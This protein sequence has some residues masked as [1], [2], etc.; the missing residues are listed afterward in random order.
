MMKT[1]Y[2][3]N[4]YK[5]AIIFVTAIILL[6]VT[7]LIRSSSAYAA[8]NGGNLIDN[9]LFRNTNSMSA[10]QIQS[11][12]SSKGS[13]LASRSFVLN[14]YAADSKEREWYTAVGAPCDQNIPASQIIYY[15]SKIYGVNP[16]VVLATLQKEQ[17][18]ITS[19][20][21]TSWQISQAMGYACP[22]SGSCSSESNFFYQIDSGVWVMRYH[23]ERARGNMDWWNPSTT[24]TCG[25][26]KK[27][28][29]PNLYPNQNVRF[30]DEN[31]VL[32]RTHYI[33]N[34]AT[35]S[36]Y[37]YTPHAYNNPEGLYG[38]DPYGS[39]GMYYSGS[40]NFVYWFEIWF[41]PTQSDDTF[42][43]HPNGTLIALN[44]KVYKIENGE[45][46]HITHP[47]VLFS[48]RY[49][50][51]DVRKAKTGDYELPIGAPINTLAAG[52]IY[53]TKD[54]PVYVVEYED[55]TLKR[56][57]ISYASFI[58]L[59]YDWSKV[60]VTVTSVAPRSTHSSLLTN[61]LHPSGSIVV[62][63]Q[64]G[65][66][67]LIEE[68]KKRH[69]VNPIA[70]ESHN[71]NWSDVQ[72]ITSLDRALPNG[73]PLEIRSGTMLL[74]GGIYVV[75]EDANGAFKRPLGPW[76][77]YADRLEYTS[78]DWIVTPSSLLPKRTGSTYTC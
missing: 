56:R 16:Q 78:S 9:V 25:T 39:T 48:Y 50:W 7:L 33:Q 32:Y 2:I 38:R 21:P 44:N 59:E 47:D 55:G 24:W 18:L 13:G 72:E 77:C 64:A 27:Y 10:A 65:K 12:L 14:C 30:Y 29:K 22:T 37:C 49:T 74:S 17:S 71:Y 1:Y 51:N 57:H 35:S 6:V 4:N 36:L 34:A 31:D 68:G 40:Y 70:F 66:V 41:G 76:E 19:P 52:T 63:K 62:D 61:N 20:N 8:Y 73:K 11:F 42:S 3:L 23:Y 26:E 67:Y 60:L 75:D 28:Y 53:R 5:K 45:L 43:P 54:S 15:A 46:R 58:A 69:I